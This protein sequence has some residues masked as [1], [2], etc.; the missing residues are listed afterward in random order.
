MKLGTLQTFAAML[1]CCLFAPAVVEDDMGVQH[2]PAAP[3]CIPSG[4]AQ[5]IWRNAILHKP[6]CM[7]QSSLGN[8]SAH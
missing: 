6:W 4:A 3:A 5:L 8:G 1:S 2:K 7:L